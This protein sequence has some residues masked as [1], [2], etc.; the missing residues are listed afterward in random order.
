VTAIQTEARNAGLAEITT[1]LKDQRARRLDL[2]TTAP[3]LAA[4]NGMLT[5][6]PGEAV[7]GRQG[8]T[9]ATGT[10][11]PTAVFDEGL[12]A[13]LGVPVAWLKHT[14]EH[15]P[16]I[17]D[18]TVNALLHGGGDLIV[19]EGGGDPV[20]QYPP[21]GDKHLVRLL[22]GDDGEEGVARAFLSKN[23][24]INDSLDFLT[25]IVSGMQQS[26]V[27]VRPTYCDLSDRR[28]YVRFACPEI[29][30][31]SPNWLQ[32]YKSPFGPEGRQRAGG[33]QRIEPASDLWG[34]ANDWA[35]HRGLDVGT[36]VGLG[37]IASNSDVGNG[38]A[39]LAPQVR[40]VVCRN[41]QTITKDASRRIHLGSEMA[42]G[43]VDWSADTL[44]AELEL[45]AGQTR[46]AVRAWLTQDYL[47]DEVARVEALAGHPIRK[48]D[49]A[50]REIVTAA[51]FTQEAADDILG[52][53][54]EGGQGAT[55]GALGSAMTAY[56]QT[57][58]SPELAAR[59]EDQAFAVMEKA[60]AR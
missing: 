15:R 59:L 51:K 6:A 20:Y 2:V 18:S 30:A 17:Y 45:I 43:V 4:F 31:A 21:N 44:D 38:A 24:R 35:A 12:A 56:A 40:V 46:D 54:I 7:A 23:Y 36:V 11:R 14:R 3:A 27:T 42:E 39:Y 58:D 52:L 33:P 50:V 55:A 57:V 9:Q 13:R 32:G 41:G 26:G 1:I 5:V 19:P 60:A 22:K 29:W 10:Y 34:N 37:L 16:D 49:T 28:M 48:A 47:N 8:V 53:M 25:A